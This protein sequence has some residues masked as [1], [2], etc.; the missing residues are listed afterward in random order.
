MAD[1]VDR[2]ALIERIEELYCKEC[3]S[4]NGVRCRACGTGDAIEMIE[5][6]P[7]VEP[8]REEKRGE[9]IDKRG[10]YYCSVCGSAKPH[11]VDG[12]LITYWVGDYCRMCGALLG[13]DMRKP[14]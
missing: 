8:K 4:Y 3:N 7:T 13:A 5:S 14:D 12:E 2:Q 11:F 10:R 6:A 9:W 1:L